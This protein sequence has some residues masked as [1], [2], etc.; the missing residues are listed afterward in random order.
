MITEYYTIKDNHATNIEFVLCVP[1]PIKNTNGYEVAI[2]MLGMFENICPIQGDSAFQALQNAIMFVNKIIYDY[3]MKGF[4]IFYSENNENY[5][6]ISFPDMSLS[7]GG[8]E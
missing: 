4:E 5:M 2:A 8:I 1:K 7:W 3:Q 6:E